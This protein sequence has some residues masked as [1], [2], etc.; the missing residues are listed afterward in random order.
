MKPS[1]EVKVTDAE[2]RTRE[3]AQGLKVLTRSLKAMSL[4]LRRKSLYKL[5]L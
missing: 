3:T 2:G 1:L 4:L 5:G